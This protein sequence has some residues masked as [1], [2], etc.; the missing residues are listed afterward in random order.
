MI[1]CRVNLL[2]IKRLPIQFAKITGSQSTSTLEKVPRD[3]NITFSE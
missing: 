2:Y 3:K 1:Y